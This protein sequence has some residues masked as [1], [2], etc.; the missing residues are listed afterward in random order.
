MVNF[1]K[2]FLLIA[3]YFWRFIA[4]QICK[5]KDN[6]K[7]LVVVIIVYNVNSDFYNKI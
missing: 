6:N 7:Y 4:Q 2:K 3:L 1:L 5:K